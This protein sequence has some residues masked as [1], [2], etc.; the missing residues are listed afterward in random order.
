MIYYPY[1]TPG[2]IDSNGRFNFSVQGVWDGDRYSCYRDWPAGA[3]GRASGHGASQMSYSGSL[4]E[5]NKSLWGDYS[6]CS[7]GLD[8]LIS[9]NL[10]RFRHR[11]IPASAPSPNRF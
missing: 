1:E 8:F 7:E 11:S 2:T 9:S 3:V 4:A 10:M 5:N 6:G